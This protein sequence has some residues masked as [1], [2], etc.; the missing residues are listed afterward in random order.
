ML[1]DISKR[2]RKC[3]IEETTDIP[4]HVELYKIIQ[5]LARKQIKMEEQIKKLQ[6]KQRK[7]NIIEWL[8]KNKIPE[9]GYDEWMKNITM[10]HSI[11]EYLFENTIMDTIDNIFNLHLNSQKVNPLICVNQKANIIYIYENEEIKWKKMTMEEFVILL[12]TIDRKLFRMMCD[13]QKENMQKLNNDD[14]LE[15]KFNNAMIKLTGVNYNLES[16]IVS[17]IRTNLYNKKKYDLSIIE[18]EYE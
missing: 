15:I 12:K 7:I 14:Y 8:N 13:W 18:N 4:T 2:E 11:V 3:Q 17:K 10:N 6:T 5:E 1:Q 16:S 9:I